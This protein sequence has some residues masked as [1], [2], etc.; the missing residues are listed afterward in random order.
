VLD[1]VKDALRAP[2]RGGRKRPSWT[3]SP[4]GGNQASG[5]GEGTGASSVEQRNN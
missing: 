4:C 1:V 5:W 2:L 3:T